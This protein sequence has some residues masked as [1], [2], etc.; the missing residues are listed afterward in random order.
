MNIIEKDFHGQA[1]MT[2]RYFIIRP[3]PPKKARK[4]RDYLIV[5]RSQKVGLGIIK[6]HGAW[7]QYIFEPEAD[8]IWSHD[9]LEDVQKFILH[10]MEERKKRVL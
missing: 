7:R 2:S 8:T 1:E 3:Q 9:C 5:S 4:T 6:W 10:L